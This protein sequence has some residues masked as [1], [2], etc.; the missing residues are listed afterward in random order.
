MRIEF[1][2]IIMMCKCNDRG[3]FRYR[4]DWTQIILE[5][6]THSSLHLYRKPCFTRSSRNPHATL[7]HL[8]CDIRTTNA[9]G[10]PQGVALGLYREET[11][12]DRHRC[13]RE[14]ERR[15]GNGAV[16]IAKRVTESSW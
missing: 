9:T 2:L 13:S 6:M 4:W 8:V 16:D 15:T 5:N 3:D 12:A 7:I 10:E 11:C 1:E 14:G